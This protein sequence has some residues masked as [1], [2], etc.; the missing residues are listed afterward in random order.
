MKNLPKVTNTKNP[1]ISENL[2]VFERYLL[3][4]TPTNERVERQVV[5]LSKDRQLAIP[6]VVDVWANRVLRNASGKPVV[7]F[8]WRFWSNDQASKPVKI[9]PTV[10][11]GRL[12]LTGTRIPV[13][14]IAGRRRS[15]ESIEEIAQNY[16]LPTENIA[17][18]LQHMDRKAA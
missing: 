15:G 10:M 8:P 9:D 6:K 18:A 12:V 13:N 17:K 4:D 5:N 11:S 7:I 16:Q 3:Y 1:L 2:K 14:F